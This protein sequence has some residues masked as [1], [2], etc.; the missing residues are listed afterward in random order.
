MKAIKNTT[1]RV[2]SVQKAA[3]ML[4]KA[5]TGKGYLFGYVDEVNLQAVF[6]QEDVG[7]V[8]PLRPDQERVEIQLATQSVVPSV[9]STYDTMPIGRMTGQANENQMQSFRDK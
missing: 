8:G 7:S 4:A 3:A 6:F 1:I 5:A 9:S 2:E